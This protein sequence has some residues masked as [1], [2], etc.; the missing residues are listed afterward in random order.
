[1]PTRE[2]LS[3]PGRPLQTMASMTS[4]LYG[5]NTIDVGGTALLLTTT[6]GGDAV[7]LTRPQ[8]PGRPAVHDF[9]FRSD[10]NSEMAEHYAPAVRNYDPNAL[11]EP[12]WAEATLCGRVWAVMIG[13]EGGALSDYNH[14]AFAPTCRRCLALIDR[15]FPKPQVDP[16]LPL[17]AQVAADLVCERGYAEL[18]GVPGDQQA[19]LRKAVRELVRKR[20]GHR[21]QTYFHDGWV[22]VVCEAVYAQHEQEYSREA[23]DAM[24]ELLFGDGKSQPSPRPDWTVSWDTWDV[25]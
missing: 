3:A 18:R 9:Y 12:R 19:A 6:S 11:L 23:A 25:G 20:T 4:R 21:S 16:R 7:H 15:H 14:V 10:E 2:P 1:M 13:G 22:H 5:A 17:V 8:D 24:G